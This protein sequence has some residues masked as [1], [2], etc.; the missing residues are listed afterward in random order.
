MSAERRR[1][2]HAAAWAGAA[3]GDADGPREATSAGA[4][5][6]G[7]VV[8]FYTHAIHRA[9]PPPRRGARSREIEQRDRAIGGGGGERGAVGQS[10]APARVS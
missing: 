2:F 3:D 5:R 1:A 10:A 8:F 7:D 6:A 9:P 4:L